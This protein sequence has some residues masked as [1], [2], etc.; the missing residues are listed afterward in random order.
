MRELTEVVSV[1]FD[2]GMM[3]GI[4]DAVYSLLAFFWQK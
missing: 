2:S 3:G 4:L 1:A